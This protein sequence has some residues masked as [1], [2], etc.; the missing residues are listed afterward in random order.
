MSNESEG[1]NSNASSL[2]TTVTNNPIRAESVSPL[3]LPPGLPS[4]ASNAANSVVA[5]SLHLKLQNAA[6]NAHQYPPFVSAVAAA[7]HNQIGH[8]QQQ[9]QQQQPLNNR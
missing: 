9:Q 7:L 1:S 4:S 5:Q 8:H 3:P 6:E 2:V